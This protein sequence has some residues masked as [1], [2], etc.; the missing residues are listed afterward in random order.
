MTRF[1]FCLLLALL[2]GC[3]GGASDV[4]LGKDVPIK[5]PKDK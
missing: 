4:N 5:K 1:I 3:G 2:A